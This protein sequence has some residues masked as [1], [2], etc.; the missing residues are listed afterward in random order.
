MRLVGDIKLCAGSVVEIEGFGIFDGK[1]F[2]ETAV[3]NLD[4]SGYITEIEVRKT[5]EGY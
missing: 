1:Y 2:I 3:H 4:S 5:L